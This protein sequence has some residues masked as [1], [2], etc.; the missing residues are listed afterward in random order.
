MVRI[1]FYDE[2]KTLGRTNEIYKLSFSEINK[3]WNDKFMRETS[4]KYSDGLL[5][6]RRKEI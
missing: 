5:T 2:R 3:W 1:N 4:I 6:L